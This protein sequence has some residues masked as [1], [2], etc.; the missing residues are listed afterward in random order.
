MSVTL[1]ASVLMSARFQSEPFHGEATDLLLRLMVAGELVVSPTLLL[2]EV[3]AATARKTGR[4]TDAEEAV[5][6]LLRLPNQ[7]F[8]PLDSIAAEDAGRLAGRLK[9]RGADAVYAWVAQKSSSAFITLDQE[10]QNKVKGGTGLL[11]AKGMAGST[12]G[13][14]MEDREF[15]SS[16]RCRSRAGL[17]CEPYRGAAC[18]AYAVF[19]WPCRSSSSTFSARK[20]L[21]RDW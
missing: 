8:M 15:I 13:G 2:V 21:S 20:T 12:Q 5:R 6:E 17:D 18:S 19:A 1:D 16:E 9:L 7:S 3:A 10:V 11:C 14:S 4:A